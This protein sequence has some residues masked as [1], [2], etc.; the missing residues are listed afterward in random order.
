MNAPDGTP[1]PRELEIQVDIEAILEVGK[2][3]RT[4]GSFTPAVAA[5]ARAAG[6]R[7]ERRRATWARIISTEA[8]DLARVRHRVTAA[9][10]D[11]SWAAV[12]ALS[13]LERD[14]VAARAA[15]LAA[16]EERKRQAGDPQAI[17]ATL[18]E[19]FRA[20]PPGMQDEIRA[21]LWG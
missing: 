5:I 14:I 3:A 10:E 19:T 1:S 21:M 9:T 8:D 15:E 20:L 11:G 16:I 2:E 7:S 13:S 6:L 4:A 18:V 17:M 12:S